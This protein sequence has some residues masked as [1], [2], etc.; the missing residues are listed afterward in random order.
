MSI[1]DTVIPWDDL[2]DA[3]ENL[4]EWD[5]LG[6]L[7]AHD[8]ISDANNLDDSMILARKGTAWKPSVQR[9]CWESV[10]RLGRI[11]R[12]LDALE[13]GDKG[14]YI[15]QNGPEFFA[16]ERGRVRPITG[17]AM[18]DRVVS[19]SLNDIIL[20]PAIRPH[21]IYDNAASLKGKGVD[22]A[23]KRMAAHLQRY[24]Q[25]EG[26]NSGYI[27]IKDQSKYYDNIDHDIAYRE[28]CRFTKNTLAR[29]L[30]KVLLEH[31]ELDVSDLSDELFA[32]AKRQRFDR[33]KW[34]LGNHPKAG[35]KYLRKG[36]SVGDQMS[37]TIGV[38]YPWRVD[39]EAKIV[40]GSKYYARY[41]DDSYDI[42]RDLNRLRQRA[43]AIDRAADEIKL[44]TNERKTHIHR[45]DKGFVYLQRK[46]RLLP[47][48]TVD[49][50]ILPK[51]LTRFRHKLKA[52]R[53]FV[54]EGK[55]TTQEA[56]ETAKSWIYARRDIITYMQ[57]RRLELLVLN[58]YGREAYEYVYD[59][60]EKWRA[61]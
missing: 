24:Y 38:F 56:A 12:A 44:F 34:R 40:Q 15:P 33:V 25:R 1:F 30:A 9:F 36:V 43:A 60:H 37:Q 14:A 52:L 31:A 26:T 48:G 47:D 10:S 3:E 49:M 46:Y 5:T 8:P 54:D 53:R 42:D 19:H 39:N 21:L 29:K 32:V 22:F 41:M 58:L 13:R 61:H 57:L 51:A 55:I 35:M 7:Q 2:P 50:K 20:M 11:Q 16:N 17:Q 18:E 6:E 28:I 59:H 27:R 23:R 45:I 4:Y